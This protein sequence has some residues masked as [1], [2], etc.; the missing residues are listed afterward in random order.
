MPQTLSAEG[1]MS[2]GCISIYMCVLFSFPRYLKST[3]TVGIISGT[4]VNEILPLLLCW[5]DFGWKKVKLKSRE[6]KLRQPDPSAWSMLHYKY[7]DVPVIKKISCLHG[8][9]LMT[10]KSVSADFAGR[11]ESRNCRTLCRYGL[12][13]WHTSAVTASFWCYG[14]VVLQT[15]PICFVV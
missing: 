7:H 5:V 14:M 15:R 12:L 13:I 3:R 6:V 9:R 10:K 2:S 8:A 1:I 11:Q 4:P